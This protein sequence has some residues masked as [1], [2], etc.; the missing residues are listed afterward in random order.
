MRTTLVVVGMTDHIKNQLP[1]FFSD[2]QLLDVQEPELAKY[3]TEA[4][5]IVRKCKRSKI[6]F[7]LPNAAPA[8]CALLSAKLC[9]ARL[10]NPEEEKKPAFFL[11]E[12][13]G[14]R[15]RILEVP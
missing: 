10:P 1:N 3:Y 6:V 12:W 13:T 9:K 4:N 14:Q 11:V 2:Y 5:S 15:F 7:F 8:F